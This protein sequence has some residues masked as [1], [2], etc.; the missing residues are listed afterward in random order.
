MLNCMHKLQDSIVD[1]KD[2]IIGISKHMYLDF[3]SLEG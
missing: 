2:I 3:E 1:L